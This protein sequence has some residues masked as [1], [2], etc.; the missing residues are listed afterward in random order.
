[1]GRATD[2]RKPLQASTRRMQRKKHFGAQME[3]DLGPLQTKQQINGKRR[4]GHAIKS[5]HCVLISSASV[6]SSV[7]NST[8]TGPLLIIA[9]TLSMATFAR[10]AAG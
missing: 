10:S 9:W 1:M 3:M 8:P 7:M 6:G 4:F 2:A 5:R